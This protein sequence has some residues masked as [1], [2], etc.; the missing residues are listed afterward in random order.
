MDCCLPVLCP[1]D[2]PGKNIGVG[3]YFLFQGIFPTQGS[4]PGLLHCRQILHHLSQQGSPSVLISISKYMKLHSK[5]WVD[6]L[7]RVERMDG[8]VGRVS[9]EDKKKLFRKRISRWHTGKESACQCR[10]CKR[11]RFIP[12]SGWSAGV[13]NGNPLQYSCLEYSM[14][15][16]AWWV[17]GGKESDTIE[18]T[19]TRIHRSQYTNITFI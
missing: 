12:G 14:D 8:L 1:W 17:H 6:M 18:P 9:R 4:N 3:C 16:G 2:S 10:R 13:G 5:L 7:S 11:C 19:H 15:R